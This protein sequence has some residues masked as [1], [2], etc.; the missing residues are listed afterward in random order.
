VV[1]A[2]LPGFCEQQQAVTE[3][4]II[5]SHGGTSSSASSTQSMAAA[6][7]PG[8]LPGVYRSCE[9]FSQPSMGR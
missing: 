6:S 7:I 9:P 3:K 2:D 8:K 5:I 4:Q 1:A